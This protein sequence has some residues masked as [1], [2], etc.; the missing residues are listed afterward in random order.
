M[1]GNMDSIV[2]WNII[3]LIGNICLLLWNTYID[4]IGKD[5]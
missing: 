4:Y 2:E 1:F 3:I 5:I